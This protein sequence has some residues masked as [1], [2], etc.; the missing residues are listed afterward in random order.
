M[1]DFLGVKTFKLIQRACSLPPGEG[2]V[3]RGSQIRE[4]QWWHGGL[5]GRGLSSPCTQGWSSARGGMRR[6]IPALKALV[7]GGHS[8]DVFEQKHDPGDVK[9]PSQETPPSLPPSCVG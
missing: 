4:L 5:A 8:V 1:G 3:M 6:A 7:L 9:R 2:L